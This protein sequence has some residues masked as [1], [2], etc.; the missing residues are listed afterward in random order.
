MMILQII[1]GETCMIKRVKIL[2]LIIHNE[3]EATP[4]LTPNAAGQ[5]SRMKAF[6]HDNTNNYR[7]NLHDKESKNTSSHHT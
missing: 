6:Q 1:I 5:C 4:V 7:S 2:R 3:V